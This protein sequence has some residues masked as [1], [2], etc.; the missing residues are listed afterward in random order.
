MLLECL[1][2]WTRLKVKVFKHP[3]H[4]VDPV[5]IILP[6]TLYCEAKLE[7]QGCSA[8]YKVTQFP[9]NKTNRAPAP[10][11][12][13]ADADFLQTAIMII[14]HRK[15]TGK[16]KLPEK[17]RRNERRRRRRSSPTRPRAK[18]WKP[19]SHNHNR[20]SR[21]FGWNGRPSHFYGERV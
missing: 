1:G 8:A 17:P 18:V 12:P 5:G 10:V 13:D 9:I 2:R 14:Q 6:Y 11:N 21:G 20:K 4:S 15:R 3:Y 7:A 19:I 16:T